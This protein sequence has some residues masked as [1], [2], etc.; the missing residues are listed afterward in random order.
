MHCRGDG[1][2]TGVWIQC[3]LKRDQANGYTSQI[4]T[5]QESRRHILPT[6]FLSLTIDSIEH[7]GGNVDC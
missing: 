3:T 6:M 1:R 5:I 4:T 2:E 7:T